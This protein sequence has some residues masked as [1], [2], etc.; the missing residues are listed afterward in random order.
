ML[1]LERLSP[2]ERAAFLLHDVFGVALDEI[3]TTLNRDASAVRQLAVR[4]RRH[5][6]DARPR[7]PVERE[8]GVETLA[9][10]RSTIGN[11]PR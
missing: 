5:V 4:A 11:I 8:E 3:A 10:H 9:V 6:R 7:Y 2:L 1:A